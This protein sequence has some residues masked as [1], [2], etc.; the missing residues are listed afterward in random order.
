M[1]EG[2][3]QFQLH[4]L[5]LGLRD[6]QG[7]FAY[8]DLND[9]CATLCYEGPQK[10]FAFCGFAVALNWKWLYARVP[11]HNL[12]VQFPALKLVLISVKRAYIGDH[13]GDFYKGAMHGSCL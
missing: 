5:S 8:S 11:S 3:D 2:T 10:N 6:E 9:A 7:S 1:Y 4:V 12:H 13:L